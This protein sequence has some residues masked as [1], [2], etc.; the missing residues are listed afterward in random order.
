MLDPII[1]VLKTIL[2]F[3]YNFTSSYGL[4][5]ILLTIF[6]RLILLPLTIKQTKSMKAIQE[7]QPKLKELQEKYKNDK[8]RLQKEVMSFYSENK[9]NPLSGCLPLLL[10]LPIMFALFQLLMNKALAVKFAKEQ[11]LWISNL[12]KPDTVLIV[13]MVVSTYASQAMVAKDKQQKTMM[14]PMTMM[15]GVIA[16]RLPAGVLIYW[17]VTN[18]WTLGQQYVQY[19]GMPSQQKESQTTKQ[20][21]PSPEKPKKAKKNKTGGTKIK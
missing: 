18:V 5:I 2:D 14:L 9:V 10:Q 21:L 1:S 20:I 16:L 8:E 19:G 11:F 15:M 3:F 13:L 6:I 17:V 4:S 7:L 12:S